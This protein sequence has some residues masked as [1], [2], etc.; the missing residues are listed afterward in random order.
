MTSVQSITFQL[1]DCGRP[2][3]TSPRCAANKFNYRFSGFDGG[4]NPGQRLQHLG[5]Q[6][7][8][9]DITDSDPDDCRA[10]FGCIT[11]ERKISIL[12]DKDCRANDGLFPNA[13]IGR[14]GQTQ[15]GN[16]D[17]LTASQTQGSRER[18]RQLSI[19][20]EKQSLLCSD[21]RMVYL[22]GSER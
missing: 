22:T 4:L 10:V 5:D 6:G 9:V 18:D 16:V 3:S 13:P 2:S 14:R 1:W 7:S 8:V 11:Q 19:D 12:G 21:D 15:I 20:E 17:C